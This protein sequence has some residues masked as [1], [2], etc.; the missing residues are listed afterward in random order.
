MLIITL[1]FKFN[2]GSNT[3]KPPTNQPFKYDPSNINK[4]K[5]WGWMMSSQ[6]DSQIKRKHLHA[7]PLIKEDMSYINKK[8]TWIIVPLSAT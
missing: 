5:H 4:K 3:K 6:D 8:K 7:N 1:N 2:H